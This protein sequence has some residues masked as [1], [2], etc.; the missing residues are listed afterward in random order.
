MSLERCPVCGAKVKAENLPRHAKRVHPGVDFKDRRGRTGERETLKARVSTKKA[1]YG[2][3]IALILIIGSV[4]ALGLLG[5]QEAPV[6][7]VSPLSHNFGD[8]S[9]RE[10]ST[11]VEIQNDGDTNLVITGIST[12]C[13][14]TS[15]VLRVGGRTSPTFGMHDN[16][17][18]WSETL[19]P[20]QRALLDITYDAT[21]HPD[22]GPVLRIV[23][24]GSNDPVRPEVEVEFRANVMP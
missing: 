11:T 9:Q 13:G 1:V 4:F 10:V 6:I 21:L 12:S 19:L 5:S 14:C 24:I 23:Y 3:L 22:N 17:S 8:I 7:S 16:P 15:A 20:G 18:G 2:T